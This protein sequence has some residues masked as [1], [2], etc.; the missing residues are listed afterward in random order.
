VLR[1]TI[2][3]GQIWVEDAT[4]DRYLVTKLYNEVLATFAMLRKVGAETAISRKVRARWSEE[5]LTLPGFT[6][7]QDSMVI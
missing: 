6:L 5:G 2:Q 1:R 4:G 3:R 7:T